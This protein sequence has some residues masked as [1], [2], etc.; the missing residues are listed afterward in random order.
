MSTIRITKNDNFVWLLVNEKAKE[1]YIGG[2]FSLYIIYDDDSE[3]L[4]GG[5]DHLT[6]AL[7]GGLDIGIEVGF[8]KNK[9]D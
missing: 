3:E 2:L 1:V 5:F 7:E 4:V 6:R 8:I 9:C